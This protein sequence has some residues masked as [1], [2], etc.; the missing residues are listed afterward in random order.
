SAP[1]RV[2]AK[3]ERSVV[4]PPTQARAEAQHELDSLELVEPVLKRLAEFVRIRRGEAD[5]AGGAQL[6]AGEGAVAVQRAVAEGAAEF[7]ILGQ[8]DRDGDA[9]AAVEL[10]LVGQV[11]VLVAVDET[12][13]DAI[14]IALGDPLEQGALLDAVAAPDAADNQHLHVARET[15]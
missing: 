14:R 3:R 15:A 11:A 5:G 8:E 10:E 13:V 1:L 6:G 9:V 4:V 2:A 7:E 12:Q